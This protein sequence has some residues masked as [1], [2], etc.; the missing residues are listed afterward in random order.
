MERKKYNSW[1]YFKDTT[2]E[3]DRRL[4]SQTQ[5]Q[6]PEVIYQARKTPAHKPGTKDGKK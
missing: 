4:K 1:D 2:Y 3:T 5:G 6:Q